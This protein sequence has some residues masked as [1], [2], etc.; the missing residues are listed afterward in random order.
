M[1]RRWG[2]RGPCGVFGTVAGV[3]RLCAGPARRERRFAL[4]AAGD[5]DAGAPE[6]AQRL[7]KR[8]DG[9]HGGDGCSHETIGHTGFTGTGLWVDFDR[10]LAWTC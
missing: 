7:G 10:G 8:F 5:P 4:R 9:W 2:A 6:L 3:A 1:L